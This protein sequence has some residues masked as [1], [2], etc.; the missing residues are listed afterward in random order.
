MFTDVYLQVLEEFVECGHFAP[1]TNRVKGLS[2]TIYN[3]SASTNE[4]ARRRYR[5]DP[6]AAK[7]KKACF[8][9]WYEKNKASPGYRDWATN[10]TRSRNAKLR[11]IDRELRKKRKVLSDGGSP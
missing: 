4:L 6:H 1:A 8:K 2:I 10:K 3:D 7:K 5:D 11:E 9:N